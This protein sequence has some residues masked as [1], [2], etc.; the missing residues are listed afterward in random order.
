MARA[1]ISYKHNVEPDGRLAMAFVAALTQQG[2]QVFI[3]KEIRVGQE[4]PTIIRREL[5]ASDFLV[6]LLSSTSANSEM[7]IEEVRTADELRKQ[8]GR[9]IILPIRI[10]YRDELPYDLGAKLN[11]IQYTMWE[12][13]GDQDQIVEQLRTAMGQNSSFPG[14]PPDVIPA[15]QPSPIGGATPAQPAPALHPPLPAFDPR[16]L[17]RLE[18][19]GGAVRLQ[20]PFYIER[21]AD[22]ET[23]EL[24]LQDGVTIRVKGCRQS[25]KRLSVG[26]DYTSTRAITSS[27]RC[28][29]TFRVWTSSSFRASTHCCWRWRASWLRD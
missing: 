8:R 29:S 21:E 7:V 2:H 18:A 24:I 27:R 9:P 25:G 26:R 12:K 23:K 13:E 5:E 6:L 10:D 11:R 17:D 4:W 15:G 14:S 16:W 1:F 19:P 3:D 20:S 22:E 28:I